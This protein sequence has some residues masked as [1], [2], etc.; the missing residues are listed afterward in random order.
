MSDAPALPPLPSGDVSSIQGA[1]DRLTTISAKLPPTDGLACFNRM[2]LI[3]TERVHSEVTTG[4]F[5][6]DPAFMARLDVVFVNLY[7]GAIDG[8]RADPPTAPRCWS[9]LLAN[10]SDPHIA[11]MQFALAGMSAHINHD[12]PIAVVQT[13]QECGTA[14]DQ[15]T[16][17]ADFAKVN[18]LLASLD[19]QIRESFETGVILDLDRQ[20]A[21]LENLVGE[22][23][24]GTAR[25][26][27]WVNAVAL[28]H[29]RHEALLSKP[30]VAGLDEAAALAGRSLMVPRL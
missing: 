7:L 11:P 2:Y 9:E 13:C 6:A 17:A 18:T 5:Y 19:Q 26:A 8:F 3:V 10:R 27:A 21:G 30:Y 1:V 16:H 20:A 24:I 22:F 25:E 4:H 23:G 12:L 15:G 29:L 28:W 14:P